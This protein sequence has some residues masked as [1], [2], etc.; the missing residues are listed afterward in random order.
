MLMKYKSAYQ[1]IAMGLLSFFPEHRDLERLLVTM[2]E[3]ITE[4]NRQLFLWKEQEGFIGLIGV[5]IGENQIQVTHICVNPSHRN[6]GLGKRI[7]RAL[8]EHYS[9]VPLTGDEATSEFLSRCDLHIDE[10]GKDSRPNLAV[11]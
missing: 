8:Q 3:Y 1:K 10:K 9:K 4:S 5:R 6:Q 2:K 7:V 11:L